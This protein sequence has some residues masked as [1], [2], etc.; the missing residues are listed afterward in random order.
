MIGTERAAYGSTTTGLGMSPG[1]TEQ[2]L[3]RAMRRVAR[4]VRFQRG[5]DAGVILALAGTGVAALGVCLQ[6][7]QLADE[8][9]WCF[10]VACVLPAL[11]F[12]IGALRPVAPLLLAR[13]LDRT[14][15][16]SD[17]FASA[18]SFGQ[19]PVSSRTP[20]M[21]ACIARAQLAIVHVQA[22]RA[23]PLRRPRALAS[24]AMLTLGLVGLCMLETPRQQRVSAR[25][26][27]KLRLL[28]TEDLH[29]F[30]EE[31][32]K[33]LPRAADDAEAQATARE[34]NALIEALSDQRLDRAEALRELRGLEHRIDADALHADQDALR[35]ALRGLGQALQR[36]SLAKSVAE[37]LQEGDA[38]KARAE[39][40]RLS[41]TLRGQAQKADALRK[42]AQALARTGAQSQNG[43]SAKRIQQK[44][45]E[46][47]RLLKRKKESSSDNVQDQRLL[48]KKKRELEHLERE[49]SERDSS[50]R[51]LDGLKRE[52][53]SAGQSA[54]EGHAG[55]TAEHL[56]RGAQ[57]LAKTESQ[58]TSA[59]QRRQL[60]ERV[61]QLRELLS[62]QSSAQSGQDKKPASEQAQRLSL[63]Q[64]GRAARG[65]PS[66]R[67]N[68][69]GKPSG[70]LL[71]P[72]Q[73]GGDPNTTLEMEENGSPERMSETTSQAKAGGKAQGHGGRPEANAD[74]SRLASTRVDT[75]VNANQGEGPTRSEVILEAGQRGFASRSYQR[76]H[77][78]YEKHADA[79]LE[80]DKIPGGY[81]FYVRRYFQLIRPRETNDD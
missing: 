12:L 42:L 7:T 5:L 18:W 81:R 31:V 19:L 49:Q 27:P 59:E 65:Q 54:S 10:V 68:T 71:L 73:R 77:G 44:R 30:R 14:L 52:L 16:A 3:R 38:G 45:A 80:R 8:A 62:K 32:A 34:L 43:E 13:L 28:A 50:Q 40:E 15:G 9:R 33:L 64:F 20:F 57:E 51:K 72:G 55:Q 36:D 1:A 60:R 66:G 41:Q 21:Q 24:A 6:R 78:E 11:G 25:V 53:S 74:P 79:V 22:G 63:E 46:L 58:Q 69:D 67:K 4:R 23:M 47:E 39:L 17:L 76:V 75:R 2:T 26:V 35:E 61:Q 70:T 29:A 37:A 56:Q 48:Q